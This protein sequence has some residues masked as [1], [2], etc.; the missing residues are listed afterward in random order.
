M[1]WGNHINILFHYANPWWITVENF[2]TS[3]SK[4]L[5]I[6]HCK[7]GAFFWG[8]PIIGQASGVLVLE[9]LIWYSY[10]Y[11]HSIRFNSLLRKL[12]KFSGMWMI[13]MHIDFHAAN[14]KLRFLLNSSR[15]KD[16]T[17]KLKLLLLCGNWNQIVIL[18][19]IF[20]LGLIFF[21]ADT[22]SW[23]LFAIQCFRWYILCKR[24]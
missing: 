10:S 12:S 8:H 23:I 19:L 24:K 18:G 20:W 21:D 7:F 6:W 16:L 15:N 1:E 3:N 9:S 14:D 2:K 4:F 5:K 22:W 11:I 13:R 17:Q